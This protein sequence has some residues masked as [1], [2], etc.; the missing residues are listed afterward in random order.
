MLQIKVIEQ[1]RN[2]FYTRIEFLIKF[3]YNNKI[4][5]SMRYKFDFYSN[6]N[7]TKK[8]KIFNLADVTLNHTKRNLKNVL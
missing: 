3:S 1:K 5:Y 8:K 4:T 6:L 7:A 2:L